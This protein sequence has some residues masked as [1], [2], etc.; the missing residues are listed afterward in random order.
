[1][2]TFFHGMSTLGC[3]IAGLFFLRF[4]RQ[5]LDRFFLLFALAFFILAFDYGILGLASFA[6][7]WRPYVYGVRLLAFALIIAAIAEKNRKSANRRVP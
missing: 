7:E 4:W 6:T 2:Q 3:T 1:M 5:S